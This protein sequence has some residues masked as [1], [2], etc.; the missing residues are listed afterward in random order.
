MIFFSR[1]D[2]VQ[3]SRCFCPPKSPMN[4]VGHRSPRWGHRW[5]SGFF[6]RPG[7]VLEPRTRMER[8]AWVY[9]C[10]PVFSVGNVRIKS[11][12]MN[13]VGQVAGSPKW[14]TQSK[15][16]DEKFLIYRWS[17][18]SAAI[19]CDHSYQS[20][21]STSPNSI[22]DFCIFEFSRTFAAG[23]I[24]RSAGTKIFSMSG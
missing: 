23:R 10:P 9:G 20:W 21:Q 8:V 3:K 17:I 14:D 15:K 1:L 7:M 16:A 12:K 5:S 13:K 11:R 18:E 24:V 2:F 19:F 22:G 4:K 6:L